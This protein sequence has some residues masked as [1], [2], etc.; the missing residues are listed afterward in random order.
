ML[1]AEDSGDICKEERWGDKEKMWRRWH[2]AFFLC[3]ERHRALWS[4]VLQDAIGGS[5]YKNVFLVKN[6]SW[7][8]C[9]NWSDMMLVFNKTCAC[10]C[11]EIDAALYLK[12]IS[13]FCEK[14]V[15]ITCS[16]LSVNMGTSHGQFEEHPFRCW[17]EG[18]KYMKWQVLVCQLDGFGVANLE[19]IGQSDSWGYVFFIGEVR[20][21]C[22]C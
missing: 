21:H 22:S 5:W 14:R 4:G 7:K 15:S 3:D 13:R 18:G 20:G 9:C 19:P 11:S 10:D 17:M 16:W 1:L 2:L 8:Y 6:L 12:G